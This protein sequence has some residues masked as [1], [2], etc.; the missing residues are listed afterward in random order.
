M[1]K[2]GVMVEGVR[3]VTFCCGA[4]GCFPCDSC[5][6]EIWVKRAR[7]CWFRVMVEGMLEMGEPIPM[8]KSYGPF[9]DRVLKRGDFVV[10]MKTVEHCP[11]SASTY[12]AFFHHFN[13]G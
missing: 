11:C 7:Q 3:P 4:V 8:M 2:D 5:I 12:E 10:G 13:F 9:G 1:G 6:R